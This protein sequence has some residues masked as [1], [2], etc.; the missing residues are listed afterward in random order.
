MDD[1]LTGILG[2]EAAARNQPLTMVEL[3]AENKE[4]ELDLKGL[5]A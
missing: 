3:I 5:Q 4:L 1:A 2:R